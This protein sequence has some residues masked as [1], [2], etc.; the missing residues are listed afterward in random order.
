MFKANCLST[1]LSLTHSESHIVTWPALLYSFRGVEW[2]WHGM[3]E[4]R[5]AA[6]AGEFC[7]S[8][9]RSLCSIAGSIGSN[10][11]QWQGKEGG[12]PF[13]RVRTT[14]FDLR[15]DDLRHGAAWVKDLK[16]GRW[17]SSSKFTTRLSPS[18]LPPQTLQ[19]TSF[20]FSD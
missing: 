16:G 11:G 4:L 20:P 9:E 17:G 19:F 3:K 18:H 10:R 12:G 15:R 6:M 7:I 1:Q 5:E 2:V 13:L 14:T 8:N